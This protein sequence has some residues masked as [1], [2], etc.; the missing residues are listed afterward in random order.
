MTVNTNEEFNS[1]FNDDWVSSLLIVIDET[2]LERQQDSERIKNLSTAL[3]Y[4]S[5][6]KGKDRN[7]IDF[8]PN[9]FCVPIMKIVLC[10]SNRTKPATGFVKLN[11]LSRRI[12]I[13]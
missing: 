2:F 12:F 7:E 4:K 10:R 1:N 3:K 8:L 6:A 9:L 5:E 11:R 13:C